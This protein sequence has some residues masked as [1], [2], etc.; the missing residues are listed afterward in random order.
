MISFRQR[1]PSLQSILAVFTAC[2]LVVQAWE[3][4]NLIYNIPAIQHRETTW[5]LLGI[6]AVVQV[7]ALFES[8]VICLLL[9]G[10]AILLPTRWMR[11]QFVAQA[12]GVLLVSAA[13]AVGIHLAGQP[14]TTWSRPI[15]WL[16]CTLYLASLALSGWVIRRFPRLEG[17]IH[18]IL[19]SAGLLAWVYVTLGLAGLG[20]ILIRNLF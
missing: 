2:V 19:A 3:L 17:G 5:D 9:T 20:I 10:L 8:L 18:R 16:G 15:L 7:F 12:S 11:G 14:M 4:Y 1:L 6:L 13:W